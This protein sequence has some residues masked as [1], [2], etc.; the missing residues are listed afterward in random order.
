M[1]FDVVCVGVATLDRIAIVD[2]MPGEDTRI[3]A[4]PFVVAGGGPAATAAVALARLGARVAFCGVVG[5]D[6]AGREI[7]ASLEG[8][9]VDTRWLTAEAG[10]RTTESVILVT[11]HSGARTIITTPSTAPAAASVPLDASRWLHVDQT[12][13]A[14]VR[15]ALATTDAADRPLLSVDAGNPI[16]GLDLDGVDLYAPTATSIAA[17]VPSS[18]LEESMRRAR[19]AGARDVVVTDGSAGSRFLRGDEVA[20]VPA[21]AVDPVSTMGAG[22]VFHGA[23]LAGLVAGDDLASAVRLANVVAALSCRGLD[24]RSAIPRRSEAEDR[25]QGWNVA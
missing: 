1:E 3:V 12:G 14:P 4:E 15:A 2:A 16:A 9:G 8:E 22:D 21:F 5:D 6:A 20:T 24:G 19:A 7:R 11:R 25:L 18:S 17:S 10:T 13:Y 23:L